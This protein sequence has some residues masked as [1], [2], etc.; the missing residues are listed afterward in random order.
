MDNAIIIKASMIAWKYSDL[1]IFS[2]F[3]YIRNFLYNSADFDDILDFFDWY[4]ISQQLLVSK[5]IL[6]YITLY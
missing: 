3:I 1:I 4:F 5:R 6:F 2:C